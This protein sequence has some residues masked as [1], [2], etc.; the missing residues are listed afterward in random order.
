MYVA[1]QFVD[2]FNQ[3]KI[4]LRNKSG[5]NLRNGNNNIFIGNNTNVIDSSL[6]YNNTKTIGIILKIKKEKQD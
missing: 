3:N 1:S 5:I 6:A 4:G 2:Y